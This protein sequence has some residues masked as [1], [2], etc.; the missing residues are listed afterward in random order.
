MNMGVLGAA[1]A[2]VPAKLG[3]RVKEDYGP[4]AYITNDDMKQMMLE[5]GRPMIGGSRDYGREYDDYYQDRR[6]D[7]SSKGLTIGAIRTLAKKLA[8]PQMSRKR[9]H[10]KTR[11]KF[12]AMKSKKAMAGLAALQND[13]A[14]DVASYVAGGGVSGLGRL[15]L[16]AK[17][18]KGLKR[19]AAGT[20]G[21]GMWKNKKMGPIA[22]RGSF[23]GLGEDLPPPESVDLLTAVREIYGIAI[24]VKPLAE[25]VGAHPIMSVAAFMMVVG[26]WAGVAAYVGAGGV[27]VAKDLYKELTKK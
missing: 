14:D 2:A 17:L 8:K 3:S 7:Y 4:G 25:F 13:F 22:R 24:E 20:K 1:Q 16:G 19:G 21:R 10:V 23:S 26:A 27:D 5:Q 18:A 12:N 15:K 6:W 11:G 9:Q